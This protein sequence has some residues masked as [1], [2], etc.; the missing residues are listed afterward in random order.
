MGR[1]PST[2]T[3]DSCYSDKQVQDQNMSGSDS[4]Q[5]LAVTEAVRAFSILE[6]TVSEIYTKNTASLAHLESLARELQAATS[7]IPPELRTVTAAESP[8]QRH[9]IRNA[10]VACS[11]YFSMMILTRPFLISCIQQKCGRAGDKSR[12]DVPL[13]EG[14]D[15]PLSP[16][17]T[18]GALASIDSA[19]HVTQLIH[20]LLTTHMLF[21]NMVLIM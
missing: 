10:H 21:N 14:E 17:I 9:V 6:R 12:A 3:T 8:E 15:S 18:Q 20:E 4:G 19:I 11:Y 5:Q 1:T 2:L 13:T 7:S 16:E